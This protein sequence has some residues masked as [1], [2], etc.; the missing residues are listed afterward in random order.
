MSNRRWRHAAIPFLTLLG[1]L[2]G[3][4]MA[5]AD[6]LRVLP[7]GQ[8]P[9]DTRMGPLRGETGDF[10]LTVATSPEAWQARARQVRRDRWDPL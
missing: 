3:E 9:A 10:S 8:Q 6:P 7:P 2:S 1:L 4:S 5:L